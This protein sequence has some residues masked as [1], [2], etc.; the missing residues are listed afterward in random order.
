MA[1][2]GYFI[3]LFSLHDGGGRTSPSSSGH[4]R[5]RCTLGSPTWGRGQGRRAIVMRFVHE[6]GTGLKRSAP[7]P[8]DIDSFVMAH[9][10]HK[11]FDR[12]EWILIQGG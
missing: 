8:D 7:L 5:R 4:W 9:T 6:Y 12:G 10:S 2:G 11:I 3:P 1:F